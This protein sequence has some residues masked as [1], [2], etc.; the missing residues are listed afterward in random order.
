MPTPMKQHPLLEADNLRRAY[1]DEGRTPRDIAREAG[2]S[3]ASVYLRLEKYGI[4]LREQR[5]LPYETLY[6]LYVEEEK[7]FREIAPLV[8]FSDTQV[9]FW[10]R[11]Y[12]IQARTKRDYAEKADPDKEWLLQERAGGRG[13]EDIRQELGMKTFRFY[14]MLKR[15]EIPKTSNRERVIQHNWRYP[16]QRFS[17]A[18]RT[19]IWR[20]DNGRCQMPGCR[21]RGKRL[22][23]HHIIAV[24]NGGLTSA[25]NSILICQ[26]CHAFIRKTEE[27]YIPLFQSI[28]QCNN[29]KVK[30]TLY[31]GNP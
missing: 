8:G 21:T 10:A 3:A 24:R 13:W 18:Q 2:I 5:I 17:E 25:E 20:R 19:E 14:T 30:N 23:I 7:T 9:K 15:M 29:A 11:R 31:A 27:E 6:R 1:V 16:D 28:A 4:P 22:E 12:N 26:P